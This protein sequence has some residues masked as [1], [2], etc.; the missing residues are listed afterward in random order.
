MTSQTQRQR[1][2]TSRAQAALQIVAGLVL[3]LITAWGLWQALPIHSGI[4]LCAACA[5][6]TLVAASVVGVCFR[7]A[8]PGAYSFAVSATLLN[9][10][11]AV[12]VAL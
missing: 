6:I 11:V 4:A 5:A 9:A 10:L 8:R 7:A 12:V 1:R 2:S 3:G